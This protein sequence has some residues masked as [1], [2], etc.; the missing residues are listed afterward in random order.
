ME[1]YYTTFAVN[2]WDPEE[3]LPVRSPRWQEMSHW[4]QQEECITNY[5]PEDLEPEDMQMGRDRTGETYISMLLKRPVTGSAQFS[6][7]CA[8]HSRMAPLIVFSRELDSVHREHL[9]VVLYDRGLNLWHHIYNNG[10]PSWKLLAFMDLDL[11]VGEKHLLTAEMIFT[12]RGKFLVMCVKQKDDNSLTLEMEED[13]K[14]IYLY[15]HGFDVEYNEDD[16]MDCASRKLGVEIN[17]LFV[18]GDKYCAII[19]LTERK[20]DT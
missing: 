13:T 15:S 8:F 10:T 19:Y 1:K 6:A 9:E 14:E 2:Q 16:I 7:T 18:D 20:L 11:P 4:L 5:V 17:N 12:P 3:W